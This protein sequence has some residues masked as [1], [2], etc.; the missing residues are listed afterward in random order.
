M[1]PG[2]ATLNVLAR[3]LRTDGPVRFAT[4]WSPCDLIIVPTESAQLPGARNTT[5]S[6][7]D[8]GA[9][10]SDP[11]VLGEVETFLKLPHSRLT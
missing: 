8:H 10:I 7:L 11:V 1:V 5:T 4:W 3:D 2:S 6:C 9:I